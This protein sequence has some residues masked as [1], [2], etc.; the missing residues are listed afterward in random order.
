MPDR[1]KLVPLRGPIPREIEFARFVRLY[2]RELGE[3]E[4][5]HDHWHRSRAE[6]LIPLL[7]SPTV[8]IRSIDG[9]TVI[10]RTLSAGRWGAYVPPRFRHLVRAERGTESLLLVLATSLREDRVLTDVGAPESTVRSR[11]RRASA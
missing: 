10:R 8:W 2:T 4:A 1:P 7:G 5:T 9:A 3:G 11:R 6:L